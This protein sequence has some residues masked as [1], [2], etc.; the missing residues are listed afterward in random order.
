VIHELLIGTDPKARPVL[1]WNMLI[2]GPN[3]SYKVNFKE[4]LPARGKISKRTFAFCSVN[5]FPE[6]IRK[7]FWEGTLISL[8]LRSP[9]PRLPRGIQRKDRGTWELDFL[10]Q[11]ISNHCYR[12]C[13]ISFKFNILR[14]IKVAR[15][16]SSTRSS[17]HK[18][19][20]TRRPVLRIECIDTQSPS[21]T[22][23]PD[24]N[25]SQRPLP[26]GIILAG[27]I[28]PGMRRPWAT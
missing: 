26:D 10:N 27:Y 24:R 17:D 15:F 9:R 23:T 28:P 3:Q 20:T 7:K 16:S 2:G 21:A 1:T 22:L 25:G 19:S 13:R 6:N 4:P 5:P 8:P 11:D 12:H 18:I 14:L